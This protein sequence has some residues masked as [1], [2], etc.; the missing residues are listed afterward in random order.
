MD[1]IKESVRTV[2]DQMMTVA[3]CYLT[4]S[5]ELLNHDDLWVLHHEKAHCWREAAV[6]LS[7]KVL[8]EDPPEFPYKLPKEGSEARCL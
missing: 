7:M 2:V 8:G 1:N 3:R 6:L 5:Q 4:K